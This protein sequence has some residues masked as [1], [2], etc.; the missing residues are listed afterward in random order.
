MFE[1]GEA[2]ALLRT[3]FGLKDFRPGQRE[4]IAALLE[5]AAALAVFPTGGGKSLCYQLPALLFA[6][7]TLV[8]RRSSHDERPDRLLARGRVNAARSTRRSTRPSPGPP[9]GAAERHARSAVRRP[10]CF[11][12]ETQDLKRSCALFASTRPLAFRN[13]GHN[14]RP[15]YLKLAETARDLGVER[16]LALTATATPAVVDDIC[17]AFGIPPDCAVVTGFYRPNLT[18]VTTPVLSDDR[19]AR[20]LELLRA[21]P[22]GPT[23][24]YVTL[25]KTAELVA[26]W[27]A[28]GGL[29]A[30]AYHAGMDAAARTQVQEWWTASDRAIVVATIAFG[31]GTTSPTCATCTTTTCPRVWKATAR[32]SGGP[33]VTA[34]RRLSK[35]W[36]ARPTYPRSRTSPTGT[37]RR[38]PVCTRW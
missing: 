23:I 17:A 14:F 13:G 31:M 12:N 18:L 26:E 2:E 25:Q 35:C 20:L 29:P 6:G 10:S 22:P 7:V 32:K 21:R 4:V 28:A 3:R 19:D 11:N 9:A 38:A 24:V 5:H 1:M 27:L 37:R 33:A 30:R 36:R 8:V 34:H 15:D 16:V